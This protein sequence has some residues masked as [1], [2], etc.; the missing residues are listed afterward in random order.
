MALKNELIANRER[1]KYD[2]N[3]YA[4]AYLIFKIMIDNLLPKTVKM[5]LII[6]IIFLQFKNLLA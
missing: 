6:K 4:D 5:I 1:F 3:N 2:K